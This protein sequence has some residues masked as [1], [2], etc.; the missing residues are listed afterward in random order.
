MYT[1]TNYFYSDGCRP[2]LC[3]MNHVTNQYN[4]GIHSEDQNQKID[5]Y[6]AAFCLYALYLTHLI[7]K[8][9]RS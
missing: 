6:C 3:I 9:M 2:P 7:V 5:S 1:K 8:E 4:R